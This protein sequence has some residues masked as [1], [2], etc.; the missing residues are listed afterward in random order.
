MSHILDALRQAEDERRLG[1]PP[2]RSAIASPLR[3]ARRRSLA[4]LLGGAVLL[5]F[6]LGLGIV[7]WLGYARPPAA[8]PASSGAAPSDSTEVTQA[9]PVVAAPLTPPAPTALSEPNQPL[10]DQRQPAAV[11]RPETPQDTEIAPATPTESMPRAQLADAPRIDSLDALFEGAAESPRRSE[12]PTEAASVPLQPQDIFR[13]PDQ[14]P[15]A[16][17]ADQWDRP[18]EAPP[19]SPFP[20]DAW[21]DLPR[22]SRVG[23]PP[24]RID[25]H[26]YN[27]DP[28]RRFVRINGQ[29]RVEGDR[30]DNE[31]RI[32]AI[33][34][35]GLVLRWRGMRLAQ[36]LDR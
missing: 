16:A 6:V 33:T 19:E 1:K 2:G 7:L 28:D 8:G 30:L 18:R 13:N 21:A 22:A 5:L 3:A 31:A 27:Q 12:T 11:T 26:V 14:P 4:P 15:T 29:R 25:V 34:R 36:P 23:M 32:E 35:E 9:P 17:P 10:P 24:I 20:S